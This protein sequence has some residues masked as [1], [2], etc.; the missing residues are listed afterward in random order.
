MQYVVENS[1]FYESWLEF[2]RQDMNEILLYI[3]DGNFEKFGFAAERN[4]LCMHATIGMLN[5]NDRFYFNS[6]TLAL[7]KKVQ[8]LRNSGLGVFCTMDAGPNVK[9]L[10]QDKNLDTIRNEFCEMNF[11]EKLT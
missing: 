9:L 8:R 5:E 1:V 7:I 10:F 3:Q 6:D 11:V 2:A 4:A